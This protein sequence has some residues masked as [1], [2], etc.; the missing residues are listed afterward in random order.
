MSSSKTSRQAEPKDEK[1]TGPLF[2]R[3][4]WTGTGSVEVAV[5]DKMIEGDEGEFRV[6]NVV[7][8]R[9]WKSDDKYES[10]NSFR[11]EDLLPLAL[12]LEEAWSFIAAETS[13]R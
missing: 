8:K 2:S 12:F 6:F 4:V 5:F 10:G 9:T 13:K 3:R 7:A 1:K 11:P